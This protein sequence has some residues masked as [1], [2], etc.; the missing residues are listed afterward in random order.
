MLNHGTLFL[1][2]V[3][4]F[5]LK[6]LVC[7]HY[8]LLALVFANIAPTW[9]DGGHSSRIDWVNIRL[10]QI[11]EHLAIQ[12]L[13]IELLWLDSVKNFP[14]QGV[15]LFYK[16]GPQVIKR[17]VSQILELVFFCQRSNHRATVTFFE[18]RLQKTSNAVL[19]INGFRK[20][21]LVLESFFE[22]IFWGYRF[23]FT[24]DKLEGEIA[25]NPHEWGE[26]CG[27]LFRICV[28]V[29]TARLNL[30]VLC[31]VDYQTQVVKLGFVNRLLRVVD[32]VG[33]E[34]NG[35]R[36][37]TNVVILLFVSGTQAL[38]IENQDLDWFTIR[39]KSFNWVRPNPN[40]L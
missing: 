6:Y 23:L 15:H 29:S 26:V 30:N 12:R 20:T 32:E 18:K 16:L 4:E 37:D 39:G 17:N 3:I 25:D 5:V 33:G 14:S 7:I 8:G 19:L 10:C 21:F 34:Q 1:K 13:R 40:S 27:I 22:V 2:P 11:E 9:F 24:V 36:E 28:F 35:E 38:G 31:E